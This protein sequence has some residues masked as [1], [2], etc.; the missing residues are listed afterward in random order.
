MG[1]K[2]IDLYPSAVESEISTRVVKQCMKGESAGKISLPA[3]V[4]RARNPSLPAADF[5][6]R[7]RQMQPWACVLRRRCCRDNESF[8]QNYFHARG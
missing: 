5:N 7:C 1:N 4:N 2:K 6:I 3:G 8:L